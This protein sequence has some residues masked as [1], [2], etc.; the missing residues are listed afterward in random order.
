ML[1]RLLIGVLSFVLE[2]NEALGLGKAE[3]RHEI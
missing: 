2:E 3:L 1:G